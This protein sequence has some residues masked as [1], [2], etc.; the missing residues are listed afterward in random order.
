MYEYPP[1]TVSLSEL[2]FTTLKDGLDQ[3]YDKPLPDLVLESRFQLA[4]I[5][6]GS[7]LKFHEA[8][9]LQ[10]NISSFNIGFFHPRTKSWLLGI[11]K[12]YFLGYLNSRPNDGS[13]VTEFIENP[14]EEDYQHPDYLRGRG[15]VRYQLRF[16]YYSLGLILLEIGR[17]Q[18]LEHMSK[19]TGGPAELRA[20]LRNEKVPRLKA[21]M[22]SIYEGVVN[23][24]LGDELGSSADMEFSAADNVELRLRYSNQVVN[25]LARCKV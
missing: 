24:C 4:Y 16:D 8:G 18:S 15:K 20:H 11:D 5:L 21:K 13:A 2:K 12:P 17:W 10:K 23:L 14:K 7:L 6:A 9:W 3:Y 22:G 1:S 25:Q 19:K